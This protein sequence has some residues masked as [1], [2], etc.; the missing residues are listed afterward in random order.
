LARLKFLAMMRCGDEP[1]SLLIFRA[2]RS[3]KQSRGGGFNRKAKIA[4]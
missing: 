3:G 1:S 4:N 2:H